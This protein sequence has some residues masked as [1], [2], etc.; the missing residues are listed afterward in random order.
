MHAVGDAVVDASVWVSRLIASERHHVVTRSWL[1][2]AAR[3]GALL[4]APALMLPEVGGALARRTGEAR[5][6]RRALQQLMRVPG[7]RLIPLDQKLAEMAARLAVD[8][9]LRGADAVYVAAAKELGLPLVSW[10]A[11]QLERSARVV[12]ARTPERPSS[13]T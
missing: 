13:R 2:G 10:D 1:D 6:A 5:L 8:L 3:E 4:V 9:A 12:P 7:L 11:E